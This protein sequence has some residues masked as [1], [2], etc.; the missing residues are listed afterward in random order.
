MRSESMTIAPHFLSQI[1]FHMFLVVDSMG[2]SAMM[3]AFFCLYPW[4]HSATKL[5]SVTKRCTKDSHWL[6]Q[7]VCSQGTLHSES[8]DTCQLLKQKQSLAIHHNAPISHGKWSLLRFFSEYSTA[9]EHSTSLCL[10]ETWSN[11]CSIGLIMRNLWITA[12][13]WGKCLGL[14]IEVGPFQRIVH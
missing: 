9:A 8:H 1:T 13:N 4:V 7:H 14:C 10:W 6:I 5:K 12:K 3:Y 2:P 11:T